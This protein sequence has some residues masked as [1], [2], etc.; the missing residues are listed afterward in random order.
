[1]KTRLQI[2]QDAHALAAATIDDTDTMEVDGKLWDAAEAKGHK[3]KDFELFKVDFR[4]ARNTMTALK[5]QPAPS[6]AKAV[7]LRPAPANAKVAAQAP[8]VA[9]PAAAPA[10]KK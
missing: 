2:Y 5:R 9:V 3:G 10:P 8:R 4:N 7:L 1:M 6:E